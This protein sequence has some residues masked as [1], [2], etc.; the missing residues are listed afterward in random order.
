MQ[1]CCNSVCHGVVPKKCRRA[2]VTWQKLVILSP[3]GNTVVIVVEFSFLACTI[4]FVLPAFGLT[5]LSPLYARMTS[6][7]TGNCY[8]CT[9]SRNDTALQV[10]P[11]SVVRITTYEQNLSRNKLG[12]FGELNSLPQEL[13]NGNF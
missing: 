13:S 4:L 10:R 2:Q 7:S 3:Y 1:Y 11:R 5:L 9:L 6:D 8:S 12:E